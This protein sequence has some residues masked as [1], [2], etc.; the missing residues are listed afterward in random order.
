MSTKGIVLIAHNNDVVDYFSMAVYTAK[1]VNKF[2]NLPVTVITDSQSFYE[3]SNVFDNIIQVTPDNTNT[4]KKQK[5]INKKRHKVFDLTPYD[6]TIILDT[7]YMINSN[8][9]LKLFDDHDFK[10]HNSVRWLLENDDQECIN[11]IPILWATVMKFKKTSRTEQLF[12]LMQMV[13]DNYN[14]YSRIYKFIPSPYRNDYALTIALK[15][16]NGHLTNSMDYIN[17]RL[18]HVSDKVKV[19]RIDSTCYMLYK[20]DLGVNKRYYININNV[21]F[22]M[23][24][25]NNYLELIDE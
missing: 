9:L 1:R 18:W 3:T 11:N 7:D 19:E 6:E 12:N 10:C 21:D 5:W 17:N 24:D 14:H 13:E 4:K 22:H 15:T 23:I 2:L 20:E 8:N 25:K 16:V